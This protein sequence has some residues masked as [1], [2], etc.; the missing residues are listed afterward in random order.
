MAQVLRAVGVEGCHQDPG[1]ACGAEAPLHA[2]HLGDA[3]QHRVGGPLD[4]PGAG[5][6]EATVRTRKPHSEDQPHLRAQSGLSRPGSPCL[7]RFRIVL[8][9]DDAT[10]IAASRSGDIEYYDTNELEDQSR[11]ERLT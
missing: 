4:G 1:N 10:Q 2:H 3:G 11:W 8:M 9:P 5:Q 6:L 7:D